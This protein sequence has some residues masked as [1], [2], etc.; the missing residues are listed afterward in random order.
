MREKFALGFAAGVAAAGL[1]GAGIVALATWR[2]KTSGASSLPKQIEWDLGEIGVVADSGASGCA[3]SDELRLEQFSRNRQFF[4]EED[5]QRKIEGASVVVIGVGGVGSHAAYML[6]RAG[7][8]FLRL[9]DFDNVSLSSLNR[10]ACA[11]RADVGTPKVTALSSFLQRVV[12]SC[13]IDCVQRVFDGLHAAE[14]LLLPPSLGSSAGDNGLGKATK[15]SFVLDCIDDKE[16]K[17]ALLDYCWSNGIKV[18]SSMGAGGRSDPTRICIA[19]LAAIKGENL[20]S[21]LRVELRKQGKLGFRSYAAGSGQLQEPSKPP[22]EQLVGIPCVYSSEPPK[23]AL[24]P[25]EMSEGEKPED[26]GALPGFRVRVIPVLGCLPAIF[27]QAMAAYVLCEL[28]GGKYSLSGATNPES[29]SLVEGAVL[30][31]ATV[32]K[33]FRKA[34]E[35]ER[36]MYKNP[37]PSAFGIEDVGFLLNDVWKQRSA[38]SPSR[39]GPKALPVVLARWRLDR[40]SLPDNLVV[41]VD[42]ELEDFHATC[43]KGLQSALEELSSNQSLRSLLSAEINKRRQGGGH[44]EQRDAETVED[45]AVSALEALQKWPLLHTPFTPLGWLLNEGRRPAWLEKHLA[46]HH[47]QVMEEAYGLQTVD[48]VLRRFKWVK[49]MMGY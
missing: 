33:V 41:L 38:L 44:G 1:V 31:P 2:R 16:S 11:T 39:V 29:A 47:T 6:A 25:L 32:S 13:K 23:A 5:G 3:D 20:S 49:E 27:G 8:G 15:P 48:F 10:H 28:A 18:I 46:R 22:T 37:R 30:G 9:V 43:L 7:V 12:P 14:L 36:V 17:I 19:D 35:Q 34:A 45:G 4:G 24:L 21:A 42:S 40:P 26:F